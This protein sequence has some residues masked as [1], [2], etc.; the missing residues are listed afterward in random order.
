MAA[1]EARQDR[2]ARLQHEGAAPGDL[3]RVVER[4]GQV[5]E[6]RR[7]RRAALQIVVRRQA[8][9][10]V[11]RHHGVVR[12]RHQRVM[13]L[14]VVRRREE[15]LVRR[16]ER[17]VVSIGQVHHPPLVPAVVVG[18]P[19]QLDIEP[20]AEQPLQ[21]QKSGLGHRL[22]PG[23]D[24]HVDRTGRTLPS[25]RS[26]HRCPAPARSAATWTEWPARPRPPDRRG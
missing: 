1:G 19:L 15:R 3:D 2:R 11:V 24:G 10:I 16:N 17:H 8:E 18:V 13:R 14:V 9:T 21:L 6:Q 25:A 7:H 26:G 20:V 23:G 4:L 22:M 5:G 12:H